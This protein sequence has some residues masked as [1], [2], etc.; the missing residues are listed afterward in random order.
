MAE[1]MQLLQQHRQAKE[2]LDALDRQLKE[3]EPTEE[4]YKDFVSLVKLNPALADN[5]PK[6][7]FFK[8]NKEVVKSLLPYH[9]GIFRTADDGLRGD[10]EVASLATKLAP[11]NFQYAS[12]ALRGNRSFVLQMA[13]LTANQSPI[14][15]AEPSLRNDVEFILQAMSATSN[16]A[17]VQFCGPELA[18]NREAWERFINVEPHVIQHLPAELCG[19]KAWVQKVLPKEK[20]MLALNGLTVYN[21]PA[22]L[23]EN[24]PLCE[25]IYSKHHYNFQ[26][27]CKAV[28]S[29]PAQALAA[30]R[31]QA[32]ANRSGYVWPQIDVTL[33]ADR[34][35]MQQ[36]MVIDPVGSL[37][38]AG[39]EIAKDTSFALECIRKNPKA[40]AHATTDLLKDSEFIKQAAAA[41]AASAGVR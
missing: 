4:E 25:E 28:Q 18:A 11:G 30:L 6:A 21:L 29:N 32:Q 17:M 22:P 34:N 38:F 16:Y 5:H 37:Q 3:C 26:Y 2:A 33:K 12:S 23:K 31:S 27:H 9:P 15:Y 20:L 13:V 14:Q 19:D 41:T 36:A 39:P 7:S 10:E 24:L 1:V 40:F 8:R 35:F